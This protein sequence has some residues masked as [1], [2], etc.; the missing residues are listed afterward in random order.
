[1]HRMRTGAALLVGSALMLAACGGGSSTGSSAASSSTT[2]SASTSVGTSTTPPPSSSAPTEQKVTL[3]WW[4]NATADPLK[5]YFQQVADA[6]TKLHPNVTFKI[7]PIQNETIQTKITVALQS[8]DPPDI[9]QQWG[10]GDLATQVKSGK[11]QD[12]SAA[13]ADTIKAIGGSGAGWTVDGKQY[14]LPYSVGIVG[15]WYR[16]DLFKQAGITGTPATMDDLYSDITKLK[17]AKITPIA[18]GGKDKWP[19]AFYWGYFAVRECS[20]ATIQKATQTIDFSDPCF[21]KAGNDVKTLIAAKPFQPGFLGTSAQQGA[22]SSAGLVA[23]GQAAMELQGH[24]NSGVIGGLT[25]NKKPLSSDKLAWFG[26]PTVA[27]G[28]GAPDAAFGG[29]DGFSCS[30]KAPPACADFL[31]FLDNAENQKAF[32]ATGTGL[33]VTPDAES[34]V[35][36]ATL[37]GVLDFR[38]KSSFVELYFDKALP[39][40]IGTALNNEVSNMFAGGSSPQKIVDAV[41]KAKGQQ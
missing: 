17:A 36:D 5:G 12:I 1:M 19:D 24:W 16:P 41:A 14:G 8:N 27:G 18:V 15:F 26:F 32:A 31:N 3:T 23:N 28:Q 29:G 22:G 6:Y 34:A 35:T 25:P 13:S 37:K 38:D 20:Q 33:P 2:T 30:V 7:E 21:I 39:T 40:A 9:F 4:H 11:V 10:G